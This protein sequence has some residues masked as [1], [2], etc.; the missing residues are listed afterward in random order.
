MLPFLAIASAILYAANWAVYEALA[1]AFSISASWQLWLLG[2]ALGILS[3]SLIVSLIL[4][5]KHYNAFTRAYSLLASVWIG[6]FVYLFLASVIYGVLGL[7]PIAG[8]ALVGKILAGCA[9]LA[10]IYGMIHAKHIHIKEVEVSLSDLPAAWRDKKAVWISDLHLGQIHGSAFARK[11]VDK[12]NGRKH[13]IVFIGGDLFDGTSAPDLFKLAAPLKNLHAPLGVY[14]ITGNH[15]EFGD[16][17]KFISAVKSLG[18]EILQDKMIEIDGLQIA[19][20]DYSTASDKDRF[21]NIVSSLQIDKKKPSILL[22]HEPADIDVAQE[23]GISLQISG[24]THRA[25]MWPLGYIAHLT[26]KGFSYG[27]KAKGEMQVYTS[28]GVGTWGP[29]L[30]VGTDSE[31]VLFSFKDK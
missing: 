27:L 2:T 29:P 8:M 30:R 12:I 16:N 4:G 28:S 22:K 15:E 25:Q 24:H 23:A 5:M 3:G 17:R 31:I 10:S 13:D 7:F 19:G 11:V 6:T 14:Y 21:R 18:I 1:S 20:V 9:L 26:Y